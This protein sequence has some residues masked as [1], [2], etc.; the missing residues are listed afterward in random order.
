MTTI[1]PTNIAAA[2]TVLYD[3]DCP[4]CV[5]CWKWFAAQ[6]KIV[7]VSFV[8]QGTADAGQRFPALHVGPNQSVE[9]L[10]VVSRDGKVY[11]NDSAWIMC[12]Y[13]LRE[14]RP[15]AFRLSH[16][17]LRPLARR[18]YHV[19]SNNRLWLS[20]WFG[21]AGHDVDNQQ[22]ATRIRL[23][24]VPIDDDRYGPAPGNQNAA[25]GNA[26]ACAIR[27]RLDRKSAEQQEATR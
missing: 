6:P 16:P 2:L 19:V 1:P 8:P 11:R 15:L 9:E 12:L 13:A 23:H 18:A 7:P 21:K 25:D 27:K 10:I 4:L 5:R 22:L 24:T 3:P 20:R 17:A 14:Y 26:T